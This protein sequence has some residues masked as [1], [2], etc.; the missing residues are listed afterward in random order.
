MPATDP[1]GSGSDYVAFLQLIGVPSA[2]FEFSFEHYYGVYHS[3]DDNYDW[4]ARFGDPGFTRH[5]M[6][7]QLW[8]GIY[9]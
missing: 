9:I 3:N 8:A 2:T 1:I 7:T 6:L 5:H 4:M